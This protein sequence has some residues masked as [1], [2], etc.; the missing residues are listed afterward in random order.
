MQP[1]GGPVVPLVKTISRAS[2]DRSSAVALG[3]AAVSPTPGEIVGRPATVSPGAASSAVG[4]D[5]SRM[6]RS[7]VLADSGS[8]GTIV[9]PACSAATRPTAV[10]RLGVAHSASGPSRG[11]RLRSSLLAAFSEA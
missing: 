8:S 6:W 4:R 7:S 5:V 11:R 3:A 9:I 10:A 1:F 2:A